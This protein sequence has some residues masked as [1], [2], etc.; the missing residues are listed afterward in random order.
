MLYRLTKILLLGAALIGLCP[1][2]HANTTTAPVSEPPYSVQLAQTD[3][4]IPRDIFFLPD[5]PEAAPAAATVRI[6]LLVPLRSEALGA[7]AEAIRAGFMAAYEHEKDGVS[8]T[9]VETGDV[10]QDILTSYS[11]ATAQYDILVGPLSRSGVA[12]IAQSGEVSKPTIALTQPEVAE[13]GV[14]LPQ[15]L[16]VIGLS[17]EDEARQVA[18][19][20][21][22]NKRIDKAVV[23]FTNTPWQRRAASAFGAQWQ[24][25]GKEI[26]AIE[27]I[28][29]SGYL[30]AKDLAQLKE[31]LEVDKSAIIFAA[32]D[33]KQA[34]QLRIAIGSE[35]PLYGTSQ[36]NPV[37]LPD[38]ST[39]ER[40]KELDGIRLLDIPWQ[41]QADHPA[42]MVYPR[43]AINAEQKRSADLERLYALGI[44]AYRVAREIAFKR[45]SFEL[46]GVTGKLKVN[47]AAGTPHFERTEQPAIYRDGSVTAV[48]DSR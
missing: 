37:A 43:P 1:P 16:L 11:A 6:G 5:S 44:D 28:S 17:I 8:V 3:I 36:L 26:A 38:W 42:V 9:I 13:T 12:A 30:G 7:A 25:Q 45:T 32:L 35:I 48:T 41:L 27:L 23:I 33:E 22:K 46:D 39:A 19:W 47:F 10:P 24:K 31:Q 4:S 15:Q 21:G 14:K 34:R 29:Y 2:I 40:P 20:A 18:N